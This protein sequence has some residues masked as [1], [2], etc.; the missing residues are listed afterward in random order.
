MAICATV[1]AISSRHFS[2]SGRLLRMLGKIPLLPRCHRRLCQST[3]RFLKVSREVRVPSTLLQLVSR[4][5]TVS[6]VVEPD[7]GFA[8]WRSILHPLGKSVQTDADSREP[9]PLPLCS[10]DHFAILRLRI[11]S[12]STAREY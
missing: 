8:D 7:A 2:F 4:I 10:F 1:P 11:C 9:T 12:L 6:T 3:S 5:Y